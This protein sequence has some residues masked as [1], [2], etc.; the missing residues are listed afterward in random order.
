MPNHDAIYHRLF[1]DPRVV[2]QLLRDFVPGDFVADLD[3]DAMERINAKFHAGTGERRDGDIIWRIPL[4]PDGNAYLLLLLEFQSTPDPWMALRILVYTGLLW[5]N[6]IR[7]NRLLPDGRLPP[8][9]P[10]VLYNGEPRWTVPADLASLIGLQDGAP[11]WAWQP[12][13]R[14]QVLD[15]GAFADADLRRRDTLA[16][17][18]FR[19]ENLAEPEQVSPLM[20][21][22]IAWFRQHDGF[23]ALRPVFATLI[24]R[25]ISAAEGTRPGNRAATELLEAKSMLEDRVAAWKERWAR[26]GLEAGH[27]LGR[28]E[29]ILEGHREGAAAI[30][31]RLM[32]R[33][34][35]EL[36]AAVKHRVASAGNSE[37]EA[38]SLRLFDATSMDDVVQ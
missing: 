6:L 25:M 10:V 24:E 38:W 15:E 21:A 5:Q 2:A 14:Y 20:D 3:L 31:L 36:P 4:R 19:L 8:V 23:D 32:E 33:R 7:E 37:L 18:L 11:L 28:Q 35:G 22:V 34:F 17:L 12:A 30:L 29:G 1:S 13:M 16:A 26:E 27:R 9:F